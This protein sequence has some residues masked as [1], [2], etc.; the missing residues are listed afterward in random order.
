MK[1]LSLTWPRAIQIYWNKRKLL[2]KIKILPPEGWFGTPTSYMAAVSL[3]WDNNMADVTSC[4]NAV[5]F[6]NRFM[7]RFLAI[8]YS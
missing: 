8:N 3:F 1:T 4:E 7:L 6:R 5:L 2:H